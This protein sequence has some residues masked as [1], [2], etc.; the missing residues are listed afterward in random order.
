MTATTLLGAFLELERDQPDVP[1]L[2]EK[3]LG[4]WKQRT[5]RQVVEEVARVAAGLASLQVGHGDVVLLTAADH[6]D[7]LVLD[8]AVQALGAVVCPVREHATA[9]ELRHALA[10]SG[11]SVVV[12]DDQ[13]QAHRVLDV[14]DEGGGHVSHVVDVDPAGLHG[15]QDPRLVGL[16]AAVETGGAEDAGASLAARVSELRSDGVA[17]RVLTGGAAGT[18]RCVELTHG[19][20]LAGA[21]DVIAA[22]GLNSDDRVLS[23]RP[24][25]DPAE[26]TTTIGASLL[27]GALLALPESRSQVGSAMYEVA[28]TYVHFTR[29]WVDVTASQ[30][31]HRLQSSGG[32]KGLFAHR[33]VRQVA[34]GRATSSGSGLLV[35]YP[36]LEKLGLDKARLLV[37]SGSTLG[38]AER[39]FIDALRLPVREAYAL[40][41]AG[42][43]VTL[44]EDDGR[45]GVG[46]PLRNVQL[47]IDESDQVI[48]S[49][50]EVGDGE[51]A[52]GDRGELVD[53]RL[54]VH[55]PID[56]RVTVG[57]ATIDLGPTEARLR[58]SPYVREAV[59]AVEDDRIVLVVELAQELL[60]RWATQQGISFATFRALSATEEVGRFLRSELEPLL[61]E[62]GLPRVDDIRPLPTSLEH[63]EGALTTSGRVRRAV[64]VATVPRPSRVDAGVS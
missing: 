46:H 47:R 48:V 5:R 32:L 13:E 41:E 7:W 49:G 23:F 59:L 40:A 31:T 42:G 37:V 16:P 34:R 36:V 63:I 9:E 8:L 25:A 19:A 12:V 4:V 30:V 38:A 33:W 61:T 27:S 64:V 55:G 18:R 60:E 26:R 57:D 45:S 10:V 28:P 51:V 35:R 20:I 50:A 11:A 2:M 56:D 58:S 62:E 52:T 29:R 53:G 44:A 43:I 6:A 17:V 15:H 54:V 21:R 22:T 39:A 3:R 14:V 24:L 1:V